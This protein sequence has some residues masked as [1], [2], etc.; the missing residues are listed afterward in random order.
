MANAPILVPLDG[1]SLA[2]GALAYAQAI[3]RM[4]DAPLHL[5]EVIDFE[6]GR[7]IAV[8]DDADLKQKVREFV[9]SEAQAYLDG[10]TA[11]LTNRGLAVDV[12]LLT[13]EPVMEILAAAEKTNAFMIVMATHGRGGAQRWLVGSVADKVMRLGTRPTLLVRPPSSGAACKGEVTLRRLMV[14]LDGSPTAESALPVATRLAE[15]GGASLLLLRVEPWA[16]TAVGPE[17]LTYDFGRLDESLAAGAEEYLSSVKAQ[18]PRTIAVE[19]RLLRGSPAALLA[20]TALK[21]PIDLTIMTTHGRGGLGR[22]LLGSTADRMV[23][24]GVP[25]LLVRPSVSG[26]NHAEGPTEA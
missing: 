6:P 10:I 11:G 8:H 5:V 24:A 12:M 13:G 7:L 23:R 17:G 1:S 9:E 4:V 2:E 3:A 18:V 16:A 14:P 22:L 25:T 20:D 26:E 19:T 21:E 15:A